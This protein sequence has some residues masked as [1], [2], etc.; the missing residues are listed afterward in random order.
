MG[1]SNDLTLPEDRPI[2]DHEAAVVNWVLSNGAIE[3]SLDHLRDSVRHVRVVARC[4][5]GCAS[6]DFIV[7]GQSAS[8]RPIA[9]AVGRDSRGRANGVIVWAVD[10]GISGLEIYELEPHSAAEL[11]S[12]ESLRG[13]DS[14]AERR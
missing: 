12:V 3:G 11:P 14:L 13:W 9:E 1:S 5:C 4:A 7:H 10:S 2:S 6:V 8:A